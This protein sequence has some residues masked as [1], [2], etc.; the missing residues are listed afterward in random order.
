[1]KP[2]LREEEQEEVT[3]EKRTARS[4]SA[5]RESP[6]PRREGGRGP[7]PAEEEEEAAAA[8]AAAGRARRAANSGVAVQPPGPYACSLST[9]FVARHPWAWDA[10]T[11]ALVPG[12]S[13]AAASVCPASEEKTPVSCGG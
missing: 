1:M 8:T 10:P 13:L 9:H 2:P 12:L 11:V 5:L 7:P 4:P 3:Q 6:S